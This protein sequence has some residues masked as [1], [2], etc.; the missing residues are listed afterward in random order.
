[1][2]PRRRPAGRELPRQETRSTRVPS[3]SR[4]SVLRVL[5]ALER[6]DRVDRNQALDHVG[7]FPARGL[8]LD[9]ILLGLADQRPSQR[10]GERDTVGASVDLLRHHALIFY[11]YAFVE[12]FELVPAA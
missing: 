5:V 8:D 2:P 12:V 3:C 1:M 10:R 7:A 6:E 9:V 4:G 11:A